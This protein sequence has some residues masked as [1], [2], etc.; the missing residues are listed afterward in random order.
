LL[1]VAAKMKIKKSNWKLWNKVNIIIYALGK[2]FK[3]L[4][5]TF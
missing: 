3:V 5:R 2:R 1:T 4:I